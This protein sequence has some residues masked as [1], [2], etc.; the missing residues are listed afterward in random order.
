MCTI[1]VTGGAGYIGCQLGQLPPRALAIVPHYAVLLQ[2]IRCGG[3]SL[4]P[5]TIC[6]PE[7]LNDQNE[8]YLAARAEMPILELTGSRPGSN[9]RVC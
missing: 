8:Q 6:S 9:F 5:W 1:L 3:I 7:Q 2:G 4:F